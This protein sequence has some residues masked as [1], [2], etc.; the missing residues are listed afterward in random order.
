MRSWDASSAPPT[1][2]RSSGYA[3]LAVRDVAD[4]ELDRGAVSRSFEVDQPLNLDFGRHRARPFPFGV[5]SASA[6]LPTLR[7][8]ASN[9]VVGAEFRFESGIR[10]GDR[11]SAIH[12]A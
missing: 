12:V 4:D 8:F 9:P 6:P 2:F 7:F 5:R 11:R 10:S 1:K 3:D